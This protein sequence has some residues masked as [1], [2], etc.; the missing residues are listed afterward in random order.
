MRESTWSQTG[1]KP[2]M[3]QYLE[4]GMISIAVDTVLLPAACFLT[5]SLPT[6]KMKPA[7]YEDATKL[8]MT[9]TRL[10][11]DIQSFQVSLYFFT[12]YFFN[13]ICSWLETMVKILFKDFQTVKSFEHFQSLVTK[14]F[15]NFVG[16][17][18]Y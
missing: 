17:Q 1:Y 16:S 7:F 6:Q 3:E 14:F 5:P 4:T 9:T 10:L 18:C 11:N 12:F 2:T 15:T 8:L 13:H